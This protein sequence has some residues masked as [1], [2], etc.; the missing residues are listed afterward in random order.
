MGRE[1]GSRIVKE[2]VRAGGIRWWRNPES[3]AGP[4]STSP[5]CLAFASGWRGGDPGVGWFTSAT[6]PS[7]TLYTRL[8]PSFPKFSIKSALML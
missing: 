3:R 8:P 1:K 5:S 4:I 6:I 7:P 2:E